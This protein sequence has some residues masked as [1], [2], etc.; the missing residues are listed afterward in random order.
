MASTANL[1]VRYERRWELEAEATHE[2]EAGYDL[3]A[4]TTVLESDLDYERHLGLVRYRFDQGSNTVLANFAVG[5]LSGTTPLFERF[6]LGDSSTL[7]GWNK[8]DVAPAGGDR[9]V[10]HSLEYRYQGLAFFF[11]AGSVWDRGTDGRLRLA[12]GVGFH[13]ENVFLTVGVPL[14]ADDLSAAFMGG[15]RF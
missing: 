15:V 10:H 8:F 4:A 13:D 9:M 14:N 6:S 11:D 1:A 3:R 5:G 12:T 2:L 7:R